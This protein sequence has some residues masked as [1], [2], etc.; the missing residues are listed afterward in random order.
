MTLH[1]TLYWRYVSHLV[2]DKM[3]FHFTNCFFLGA[4]YQLTQDSHLTRKCHFKIFTP[5]F[6]IWQNEDN[7]DR[8]GSP[9]SV[10]E[11]KLIQQAVKHFPF[12][13]FVISLTAS[14]SRRLWN[15]N[16]I[17]GD[18]NHWE[19]D[20]GLLLY[21]FLLFAIFVIHLCIQIPLWP[22]TH[23]NTHN[24]VYY[25]AIDVRTSQIPIAKWNSWTF[26]REER[27]HRLHLIGDLALWQRE[28]YFLNYTPGPSSFYLFTH[29]IDSVISCDACPC[30]NYWTV[31]KYWL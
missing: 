28:M 30:A 11:F 20:L 24:H 31:P 10:N 27:D 8:T 18:Q 23:S 2:G 19:T 26:R 15:A 12:N 1:L 14:V 22:E 9:V 25:N 13:Y 4:Q 21:L 6:R 3:L 16:D 5:L 17:T 7:I 29:F